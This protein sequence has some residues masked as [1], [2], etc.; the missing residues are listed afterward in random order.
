MVTSN[1]S[2]IINKKI[3]LNTSNN[4]I[5]LNKVAQIYYINKDPEVL[6]EF[7][8]ITNKIKIDSNN[9]NSNTKDQA[10][11]QDTKN[12]TNRNTDNKIVTNSKQEDT[13][14]KHT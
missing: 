12:N 10:V 5:S 2:K 4:S 7:L 1:N 8:L 6:Q 11:V 3:N 13:K 14:L 9:T